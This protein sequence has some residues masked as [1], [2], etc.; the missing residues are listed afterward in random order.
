MAY[1][2]R[3][4]NQ[5]VIFFYFKKSNIDGYLTCYI[6]FLSKEGQWPNKFF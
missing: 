1:L 2:L 5:G 3:G 6:T 4:E